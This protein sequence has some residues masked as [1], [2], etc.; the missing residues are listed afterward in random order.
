MD[1]FC[2]ACAAKPGWAFDATKA[3]RHS[4]QR[5]FQHRPCNDYST[6]KPK[7]H[8]EA[9]PAAKDIVHTQ[10]NAQAEVKL[11]QAKG[12]QPVPVPV[13]EVQPPETKPEPAAVKPAPKFEAAPVDEAP[14]AVP[15]PD[16][17]PDNRN[18]TDKLL[19]ALQPNRPGVKLEKTSKK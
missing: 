5:C 7:V 14:C 3:F 13:Y 2:E 16:T 4:C 8:V 15:T 1:Y 10:I 12:V 6:K 19:D 18:E 11:P 9:A 17:L